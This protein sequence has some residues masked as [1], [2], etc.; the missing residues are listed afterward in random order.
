MNPIQY[1]L[2]VSLPPLCEP[3]SLVLN[4]HGLQ[5]VHAPLQVG[6]EPY[7]SEI[8]SGVLTGLGDPSRF[9]E[10]K[11]QGLV[12]SLHTTASKGLLWRRK[13]PWGRQSKDQSP[14]GGHPSGPEHSERCCPSGTPERA[15]QAA[16]ST[17]RGS[18]H[19]RPSGANRSRQAAGGHLAPT[20][21][22]RREAAP[23]GQ[24]DRDPAAA[25]SAP[26]AGG[27]APLRSQWTA[28][29]Q[30]RGSRRPRPNTARPSP[31]Y[32]SQDAERTQA[33]SKRSAAAQAQLSPLGAEGEQGSA[34]TP[35]RWPRPRAAHQ[36]SGEGRA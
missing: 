28:P 33:R 1:L 24:C 11:G 25:K 3:P 19:S 31:T 6:A 10:G 20:V 14:A 9:D 22:R 5:R 34:A 2:S 35:D 17:S 18:G 8:A 27:S 32:L 15:P 12:H 7:G 13:G 26:P 4:R 23:A 36:P 29:S 30:Q 21:H 16:P